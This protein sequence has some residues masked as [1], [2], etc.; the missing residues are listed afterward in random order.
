MRGLLI[1]R[2]QPFHLGH[3]KV[4]EHVRAAHPKET[5]VLGIG[6]SEESYTPEN[7]FTAG[8]RAEM[9]ERA[10]GSAGLTNWSAVPIPDI[11]RHPLWVAH[12][13]EIV[14]PFERVYTNNPLTKLLF[15]REH[16]ELEATPLFDRSALQGTH[17]RAALREGK[18]WKAFVPPDVAHYLESIDAP[19]RVR[20]LGPE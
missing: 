18:P 20:L 12:V 6:S 5:I 11:D 9:I 8:E 14:P 19:A 17:V 13:R 15:E 7:P 2:F 10:M 1:G 16:L 4:L 3:L